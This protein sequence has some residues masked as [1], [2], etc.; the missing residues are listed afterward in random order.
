M[1]AAPKLFSIKQSE[2]FD[3]FNPVELARL[4]GFLE[5]LELP[6]HHMLFTPGTPSEA[7]YFIEKGRVRV[8][9]LSTEGK[10]VILALLG[11]GDMI[12][13]A[14]WETGEH[15][16][17]AE[18]LEDSKI[19]QI[20]REAFQSFIRENPEF[21]IRFIQIIGARLKQ[22]QARIE[23]LVFR[24]VPSRVARL[25][26]S[27]AESHGKVTPKG[28]RVEFPLTHQEIADLVGSSRVTVTQIL[29][30]FRS[31][32]WIEIESKRVT[33]H[34]LTALEDIVKQV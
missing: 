19:Y 4:L 30:R 12:G 24:Q 18:T 23:D 7:I 9:R 22:A 20:G 31:S 8:T 28:I 2:I 13:E 14:A 11:P 10:T 21:G 6:K 17:Y 27:L 34:D 29:N 25:L 33:I 1:K 5:E 32:H 3:S 16:S 15:D 26:L